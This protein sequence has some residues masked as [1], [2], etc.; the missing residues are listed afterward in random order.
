[1]VRSHRVAL[2]HLMPGPEG[3]VWSKGGGVLAE[4]I[5]LPR[6]LKVY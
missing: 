5:S 3:S 4:T 2:D 1:M 6:H